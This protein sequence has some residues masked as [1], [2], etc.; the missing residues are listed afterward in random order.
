MTTLYTGMLAGIA[1]VTA[2]QLAGFDMRQQTELFALILSS[3]TLLAAAVKQSPRWDRLTTFQKRLILAA[4]AAVAATVSALQNGGTLESALYAG[5]NAVL[6]YLA[7]H[8]AHKAEG[9]HEDRKTAA[10]SPETSAV[11]PPVPDDDGPA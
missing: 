3:T 6:A 7:A 1:A 2:G 11:P 10:G 8:Y 5:L 4:P 9:K